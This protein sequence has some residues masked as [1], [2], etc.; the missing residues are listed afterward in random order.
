MNKNL[1]VVTV[2]QARM[3]STR[4]PYKVI[5]DLAGKPLLYRQLERISASPAAGKLVVATTTEP[6]DDYISDFCHRENIDFYRGDSSDLLDRHYKAAICFN[7]DVV[8]KI[9]SD[10]PLIDPGIITSVINSFLDNYGNYDYVSNLHPPTYP[11]GND[12]EVMTFSAL[13]NAWLNAKKDYEREHTTPYFWENPDQFKI[14]NIMWETGLDYSMKHRWTID[15][16]EDYLFVKTVYEELYPK[17]KNFSLLDILS[18]LEKKPSIKK[19]N[20][21]YNGVNWY[22]NH[23]NE[24]KSI[25]Q[26]Q[27]K[28][29]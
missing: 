26:S 9:P 7:A 29:Y 13:N 11:D 24:L 15:Y 8:V 25:S 23:L 6:A 16:E 19:I 2:V 3:L 10:C 1:N 17:N 14:G 12:V 18:L 20:E 21:K 28:L 5:M 27:T 22:R 4:Y